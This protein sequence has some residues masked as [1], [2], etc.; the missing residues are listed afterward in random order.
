VAKKELILDF[1]EYDLN[2]V[3]ADTETIRR[4]NPQRFEMEQLTTICFEDRERNVCVGYKDLGPDE[5]WVRGH[6]PGLPLM[7]GVIMCE[8]AAQLSSYYS[9]KHHLMEGIIGFGGLQEV[10]F[11]GVV[12]P[13]DRFVIVC[14]LLKLRR[15]IMT[16]EFQ[17]FV[18]QNLVCEGELKGVSLPAN[19]IIGEQAP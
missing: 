14:R 7:P 10:R 11:R 19:Q 2:Q 18:N 4:Y 16:C 1:S 6:M 15:S 8:A 12:R 17:C 13:G 5:F 9:H 3:V